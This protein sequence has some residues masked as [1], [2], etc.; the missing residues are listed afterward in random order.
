MA[1]QIGRYTVVEELRRGG[2]ARTLLCRA[3]DRR[4]VVV[5]QPLERDAGLAQRLID[6]FRV[7]RRVRHPPGGECSSSP[8][9]APSAAPTSGRRC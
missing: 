5:K 3:P 4:L 8:S 9:V 1:E 7:G 2:M 6:G